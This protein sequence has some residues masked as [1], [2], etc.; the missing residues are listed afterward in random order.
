MF[1]KRLCK[2]NGGQQCLMCKPLPWEFVSCLMQVSSGVSALQAIEQDISPSYAKAVE[3]FCEYKSVAQPNG[4]L[5]F[6]M[7][8]NDASG[9]WVCHVN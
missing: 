4:G 8:L 5:S 1:E 2:F 3:A 7:F 6:L 9:A